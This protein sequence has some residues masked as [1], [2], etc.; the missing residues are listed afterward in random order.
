MDAH[1]I[2]DGPRSVVVEPTPP[3][4]APEN[5]ARARHLEREFRAQTSDRDWAAAKEAEVRRFFAARAE[6]R[7]SRLVSVDCRTTMCRVRVAHDE[8]DAS[9]RFMEAA[10]HVP[11][12]DAAGARFP[13]PDPS[14]SLVF[15]AR[16]KTRLPRYEQPGAETRETAGGMR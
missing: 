8:G 10:G 1:S 14:A 13:D 7:G 4:I 9:D 3:T 16:E 11:P 15:L 6:A 2:H 5:A 12:F